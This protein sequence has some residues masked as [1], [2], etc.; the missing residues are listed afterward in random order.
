MWHSTH[1]GTRRSGRMEMMR[2]D[3]KRFRRM[4]LQAD[5]RTL[6]A[7]SSRPMRFVT[8]TAGD[9]AAD[10]SCSAGTIPRHR[11]RRGSVRRREIQRHGRSVPAGIRAEQRVA[12]PR[13]AP[14]SDPG[15]NGRPRRCRFRGCV[16]RGPPNAS[17]CRCPDPISHADRRAARRRTTEKSIALR[18]FRVAS[19]GLHQLP[20]AAIPVRDRP[21]TR[22]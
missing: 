1:C 10:S 11:L 18:S 12:R 3:C 2:F 13:C 4:T 8:I 21:R 17:C 19:A 20:R 5:G 7:R 9:A 15:A 16:V 14:R 22:H 6:G